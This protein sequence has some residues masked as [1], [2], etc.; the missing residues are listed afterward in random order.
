MIFVYGWC[1]LNLS[2]THFELGL[3]IKISHAQ[4]M[5][6]TSLTSVSHTQKLQRLMICNLKFIQQFIKSKK[7][8]RIRETLTLST[9]ADSRTDT[10][11][12]HII[13]HCEI[14][15]FYLQQPHQ[16]HVF[17]APFQADP[18]SQEQAYE[19]K[20]LSCRISR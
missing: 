16:H 12:G 14:L 8:S 19:K 17:R 18:H 2:K 20:R 11:D 10:H 7:K 9:N 5:F 15:G 13:P 3:I 1:W 6:Y 4:S